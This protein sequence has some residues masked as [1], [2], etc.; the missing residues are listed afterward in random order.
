MEL[1]FTVYD[2]TT[3]PTLR[4]DARLV[5]FRVYNLRES[6]H[7]VC[8]YLAARDDLRLGFIPGHHDRDLAILEGWSSAE[9]YFPNGATARAHAGRIRE[10]LDEL[11]EYAQKLEAFLSLS[12]P[13]RAVAPSAYEFERAIYD[14]LARRSLTPDQ[15]DLIELER[16]REAA[17]AAAVSSAVIHRTSPN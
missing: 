7:A 11:K 15:R 13:E 6:E 16:R 17:K 2:A 5:W 4:G 9:A 12:E 8:A 1:R 3:L 14:V 10:R